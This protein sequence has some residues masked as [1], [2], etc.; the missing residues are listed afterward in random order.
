[1][2]EEGKVLVDHKISVEQA[3]LLTNIANSLEVNLI[4]LDAERSYALKNDQWLA[5]EEELTD[6]K[7]EVMSFAQIAASWVD[8]N[9]NGPNKIMAVGSPDIISQLEV[10]I[11]SAVDDELTVNISHPSYLENTNALAS[12]QQGAA[13]LLEQFGYKQHEMVAIGDSFNDIDMI[14]YAG[15]GI[16]MGNANEKVKQAADWVTKTNDQ[17]GVAHA[18]SQIF[19]L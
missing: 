13:F 3:S 16:A 2:D 4:Y 8:R 12:K 17:D 1:V 5:M 15:V 6:K 10:E 11:K 9:S 19:D 7:S 18:L 14:R